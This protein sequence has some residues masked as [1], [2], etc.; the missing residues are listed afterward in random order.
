MTVRIKWNRV[1]RENITEVTT[2]ILPE[3]AG[4]VV[5]PLVE[6]FLPPQL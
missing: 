3:R 4:N 6:K 5:D 1:Y 2:A